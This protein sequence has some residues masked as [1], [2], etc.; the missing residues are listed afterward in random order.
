MD[1]CRKS[2]AISQYA[3]EHL[4][5]NVKDILPA[6]GTHAPMTEDEIT[7]VLQYNGMHAFAYN[8]CSL[9]CMCAYCCACILQMFGPIPHELFRIH[10]WRY[11]L[12]LGSPA[13]RSL[14]IRYDGPLRWFEYL[15]RLLF[16]L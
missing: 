6:L 15:T 1:M 14:V 4:Q 8:S 16:F 5:E 11:C 7:K 3:Y 13:C 9:Y 12:Q 2:G 10:D